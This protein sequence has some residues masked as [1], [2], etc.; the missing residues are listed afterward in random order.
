[1][2]YNSR[3]YNSDYS[4]E[5]ELDEYNSCFDTSRLDN[6]IES[7]M[8]DI[9]ELQRG[10]KRCQEYIA[11]MIRQKELAESIT[12]KYEVHLVRQSYSKP[13]KY[14]ASVH[15]I[16]NV[17][18]NFKKIVYLE[19]KRFDGKDRHIAKTHAEELAKKYN[20]EVIYNK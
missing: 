13:I 20:C 15:K 6:R 19:S 12:Y 8:D 7:A 10:I 18:N 1:M 14:F 4:L 17:P 9:K 5:R 11:F 3:Y 2:L 16:P